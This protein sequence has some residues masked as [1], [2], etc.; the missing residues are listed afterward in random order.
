MHAERNE[1]LL[2][3][4]ALR[5]PLEPPV[6]VEETHVQMKD[7]FAHHVEAEV[8]RLDDARVDGPYGHLEG[9]VAAHV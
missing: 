1:G 3:S 7:A 4:T 2:W 5:R 9:I 6:L 8:S